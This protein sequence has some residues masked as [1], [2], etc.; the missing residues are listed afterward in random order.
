MGKVLVTDSLLTDI[1][2]AIRAKTGGNS[3]LTLAQMADEIAGIETPSS[4]LKYRFGTFYGDTAGSVAASLN[5]TVDTP[6][7]EKCIIVVA[8]RDTLTTPTGWEL[9]YCTK[10]P[11]FNQWISILSK[12][13]ASSYNQTITL[14]QASSVRICAAT[15]YF[16]LNVGITEPIMQEF[17]SN[18][19]IYTY[20]IENRDDVYLCVANHAWAG[21]ATMSF[22]PNR[23][24]LPDDKTSST[25]RRLIVFVANSPIDIVFS[26]NTNIAS[27]DDRNNNR[28]FL[29]KLTT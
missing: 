26:M 14:S 15:M 10:E 9:L 23:I 28:L 21:N 20:T 19:S 12:E 8:H 1:G 22:T 13:F 17:D 29:Y 11:N 25:T 16:S 7:N 27:A 5:V 6:G 24:S 18:A 4:A 2:D 3:N